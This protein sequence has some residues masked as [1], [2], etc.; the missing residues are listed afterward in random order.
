MDTGIKATADPYVK[1]QFNGQK[2]KT[3]IIKNSLQ[4]CWNQQLEIPFSAPTFEDSISITVAD[5][6]GTSKNDVIAKFTVSLADVLA[7]KLK[8]PKWYYLTA[9]LK[10]LKAQ[11]SADGAVRIRAPNQTHRIVIFLSMFLVRRSDL[12]WKNFDVA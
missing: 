10:N 7:G 9:N 5:R 3:K 11:A 12:S 1:V 2:A 6:D 4:P 8:Q